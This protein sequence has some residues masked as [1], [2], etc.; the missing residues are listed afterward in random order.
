MALAFQ[1]MIP[2]H[3]DQVIE[4][5]R[6]SEGVGLRSDDSRDGIAAF[7]RRNPGLSFVALSED[8][9]VGAV[10]CG[11]DGR[12]GY[13]HHLAVAPAFRGKSIGRLLVE[14]CLSALDGAGI[15]KAHVHVFADNLHGQAFWDRVGWARRADMVI[16]S[17]DIRPET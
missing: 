1:P 4:L 16:M 13:L 14:S 11:S 6:A 2:D 12:R 3:Y 9:V 8:R 5:W 15:R 10:L 17:R 7:L